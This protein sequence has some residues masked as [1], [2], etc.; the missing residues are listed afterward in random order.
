MDNSTYISLSL[1]TAL[2]RQLDVTANNMANTS[3]AGFKGERVVFSSFLHRDESAATG[4]TSFLIDR[5]SYVDQQQGAITVTGNTLDVALKG[6]GWFGYETPQGQRA[7]GRDGHFAVDAQGALITMS[8]AR[9]LDIGGN[10]INLPP[11]ALNDLS[12]S[13]NGTISSLANGVISQIGV[14]TLPDVQSY[15]RIGNGMF[16][17][18]DLDG[19]RPAI[20]DG[21]TEVVQ[22]AIEGSNIQPV[23][24]MTR[25]MSIQKAYERAVE[26][27]NGEDDLR[28]DM[29]RRVGRPPS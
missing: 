6:E 13:R 23:V 5:G 21:T 2:R 10:P 11:D 16:I 4:D 27:M 19:I 14:F 1:A 3:T 8:G 26:L 9:V 28:R 22:G 24:E 17:Q 25:M 20:P 15:E 7:Y 12:I 29:L 18:P